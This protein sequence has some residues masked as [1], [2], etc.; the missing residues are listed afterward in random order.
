MNKTIAYCSIIASSAV[1]LVISVVRADLLSDSNAFLKGFVNHEFLNILSVI[2]AITLA[3]AAN[4]HLAFNTIEE[5]HNTQGALS[6]S[7][8]NLRKAAYWLIGLFLGGTAVVVLKPISCS[9][10]TC[11]ALFNSMALVIL[12]WQVLILVSLTRLVFLIEPEFP[13]PPVVNPSEPPENQSRPDTERKK[14]R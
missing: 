4:I 7:R 5:R 3:S 2:L 9:G 13:A 11:E 6:K 12:L 8:F 1:M 14:K 10:Q